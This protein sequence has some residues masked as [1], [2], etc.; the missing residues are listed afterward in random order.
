M[1]EFGAVTSGIGLCRNGRPQAKRIGAAN[2][3]LGLY[4]D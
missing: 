3:P 4:A 1:S 2:H